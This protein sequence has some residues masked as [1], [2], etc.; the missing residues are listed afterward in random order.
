MIRA[1]VFPVPLEEGT[2]LEWVDSYGAEC[3]VLEL[4][5]DEDAVVQVRMHDDE[6]GGKVSVTLEDVVEQVDQG[7][8]EFKEEE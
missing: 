1:D 2:K 4:W 6:Q 5:A 8:L 3:E 7:N